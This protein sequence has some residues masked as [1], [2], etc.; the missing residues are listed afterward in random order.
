MGILLLSF[1]RFLPGRRILTGGLFING[2]KKKKWG[3]SRALCAFLAMLTISASFP[4]NVYAQEEYSENQEE[5]ISDSEE[6]VDTENDVDYKEDMDSEEAATSEEIS[7]SE[8]VSELEEVA[9]SEE[10]S[11]SEL[12]DEESGFTFEDE[13]EEHFLTFP[14]DKLTFSSGDKVYKFNDRYC[15][16]N[17]IDPDDPTV[18]MIF[19]VPEGVYIDEEETAL[20]FTAGGKTVTYKGNAN[21]DIVT[22]AF[23]MRG[24]ELTV[25]YKYDIDKNGKPV[26]GD[27]EIVPV[28]T[29]GLSRYSVKWSSQLRII[30]SEDDNDPV[31]GITG[32]GSENGKD[33]YI[34]KDAC[35]IHARFDVDR[36]VVIDKNEDDSCKI[37][38]TF[39][40][41]EME[42]DQY[43]IYYDE[44]NAECELSVRLPEDSDFNPVLGN[45]VINVTTVSVM[46]R[47]TF[48][49]SGSGVSLIAD[50]GSKENRSKGIASANGKDYFVLN[51]TSE[52]DA[53]FNIDKYVVIDHDAEGDSKVSVTYGGKAM[54]RDAYSVFYND[55]DP[56]CN[57][58]IWLPLDKNNDPVPGNIEVKITTVS[59]MSRYTFKWTGDV[60]LSTDEESEP[61]GIVS[62]NGKDYFVHKDTDVI[63]GTFSIK[64]TAVIS[65]DS[66]GEYKVYATINGKKITDEDG[67]T[68]SYN[69]DRGQGKLT[70]DVYFEKDD[71]GHSKLGNI[72]INMTTESKKVFS[73]TGKCGD[74]TVMTL[75]TSDFD[76]QSGP[77]GGLV[78]S[79]GKYYFDVVDGMIEAR[80]KIAEGY[81]V[82]ET[83]MGV[84][85][86]KVTVGNTVIDPEVYGSSYT[87]D[88]DEDSIFFSSPTEF[89]DDKNHKILKGNISLSVTFVTSVSPYTITYG[90]YLTPDE[91]EAENFAGVVKVSGKYQILRYADEVTMIFRIKEGYY[92]QHI[93]DKDGE[94]EDYK[95]TVKVGGKAI[96]DYN[97]YCNYEDGTVYFN[98]QL[99]R[100]NEKTDDSEYIQG[101][102][103]L[104]PTFGIF[105][106]A[107]F[108]C[109]FNEVDRITT[110]G[111]GTLDRENNVALIE[112]GV[113]FKFTV[114]TGAG[115]GV[116][117]VTCGKTE[118]K[119][120]IQYYD[121]TYTITKPKGDQQIKIETGKWTGKE[122]EPVQVKVLIDDKEPSKENGLV[123]FVSGVTYNSGKKTYYTVKSKNGKCSGVEF[124]LQPPEGK[125]LADGGSYINA[126]DN[127]FYHIELHD[128]V[129]Y[130]PE[131]AVRRAMIDKSSITVNLYLTYRTCEVKF[132][133]DE[134]FD[135]CEYFFDSYNVYELLQTKYL[136]WG[137]S[138]SFGVRIKDEY[139]NDY[140]IAAVTCNGKALKS[141]T[142]S[143][144]YGELTYYT[145]EKITS[146]CTVAAQ[147]KKVDKRKIITVKCDKGVENVLARVVG[148]PIE[149]TVS[150][151]VYQFRVEAGSRV[152][153]DIIPRDH[154]RI[155][156]VQADGE[157]EVNL[158]GN[159]AEM[160]CVD[161][162]TLTITTEGIPSLYYEKLTGSKEQ[163]Y[164]E[165]YQT[166]ESY[167]TDKYDITVKKEDQNL[168][169]DRFKVEGISSQSGFASLSEDGR[170]LMINCDKA[171]DATDT[172]TVNVI[173]EGLD[174]PGI[175]RF[176]VAQ[177]VKSVSLSG[178]A[179]A[180]TSQ[181]SGTEARYG[182]TIN[183]GAD[184]ADLKV[185]T[186]TGSD[187]NSRVYIDAQAS[188]LVVETYKSAAVATS[189]ITIA[190]KNREGKKVGE[191]FVIRVD[192]PKLGAVKVKL[193]SSTDVDVTIK[194]TSDVTE[195]C[196][197]TYI[198]VSAAAVTGKKSPLAEGMA[199]TA[200]KLVKPS[201]LSKDGGIVTIGLAGKGVER[202]KGAKQKYKIGVALVQLDNTAALNST[203][204]TDGNIFAA[205][206]EATLSAST[207]KPVY[208]KKLTLKAKKAKFTR[209]EK[210]IPVATYS[211]SQGTTFKTVTKATLTG[212]ARNDTYSLGDKNSLI[213]LS[214]DGRTI[215]LTDSSK[216]YP[217]TYVLTAY[218]EGE[219]KPGTLKLTVKAPVTRII[220]DAP[221]D[222]IA[223]A[224]KKAASIKIRNS[225]Q[226][227]IGNE[228]YKP[229]SKK[230]KVTF[231]SDNEELLKCLS[232]K[233]GKVTVS[234]KYIPGED[235][236][237]NVFTVTVTAK[238]L[239]GKGTPAET[240]RTFTVTN[241]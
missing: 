11:E 18:S 185:E 74:K 237:M 136:T 215:L 171:E 2:M 114:E 71:D 184:I 197:N 201:E 158:Q 55:G 49:W 8:E 192:K 116:N 205:G 94:A 29:T 220:I 187:K 159:Q 51:N 223:K 231:S 112:E 145:I 132:N 157:T 44:E 41:K 84:Y 78:V 216:L 57:V 46:T 214:D 26:L 17:A 165:A 164:C 172:I 47:S 25:T 199:E 173:C 22:I 77:V 12:S 163:G 119:P 69:Y 99:T 6:D 60:S 130:V 1:T 166:F 82:A 42:E 168:K 15:L 64:N 58:T 175:I 238:D 96:E 133:Q 56:V 76:G 43:S 218:P 150:N 123:E 174:E 31:Y 13:E 100:Y 154:Y 226:S 109:N 134:R 4:Q 107:T 105:K 128:D 50:G 228:E 54:D 90:N 169:I 36:T 232:Y 98:A 208:A 221:A 19:D 153:F 162:T 39:N 103:S 206:K 111:G 146:D 152:T 52:I 140:E 118:L 200:T 63:S 137:S 198:K 241:K 207:R 217:G 21:K 95:V 188:E 81:R 125:R 155:S 48:K 28:F 129:L 101:D 176:D 5:V 189:D 179:G 177:S 195:A 83:A 240:S 113:N 24:H 234:K 183:K 147:L 180:E 131:E 38:V 9:E 115:Y 190:F 20:K 108:D 66:E 227:V 151:G 139:E 27:I 224:P 23:N 170:H 87:F 160:T 121:Y 59:V 229:A 213:E 122:L 92:I 156:G 61:E 212:T 235:P 102:V 211:F 239:L 141:K 45:I 72:V 79:G 182:I 86:V 126:G 37:S 85:N 10:T 106:K 75:D 233:N 148:S 142:T 209:G 204:L 32:M 138:Y 161:N 203:G 89:E 219:G 104:A 117:K 91:S 230:V 68:F 7:G 67:P 34:Y 65:S 88:I 16:D 53:N 143:G 33:Y 30:A 73:F 127:Y 196:R 135:F 110:E 225:C 144:K 181:T 62:R 149:R 193:V 80:F 186:V 194:V 124:R 70:F 35:E 210:D 97:I 120:R 236:S 178:F 191:N 3:I 14:A 93:V 167:I 222:T 202:G 40:G